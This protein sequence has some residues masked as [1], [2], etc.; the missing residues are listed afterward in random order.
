M[1]PATDLL[2]RQAN[3]EANGSDTPALVLLHFFGGSRREW[4]EAGVSLASDFRVLS[5]DTP[6]F[7]EANNVP[8]YSVSEMA[9]SFAATLAEMQLK[10]FVLVGHSMTGKVAAVMASREL[11]GLE[12][13]V[14]LT[15]SPVSPE[16]IAPGDR[17]GMLA[18]AVP[19]RADAEQ[20]VRE[21]SC[22]PMHAEVFN[23]AVEDRLRANPDAWRAWLEKGSYE[24]WSEQV[25]T[26]DLPTLVIAAEKDK[27][28]GP[29]VQREFTMP[30]FTNARLEVIA[31][32]G[33]L[34]PME[35]PNRLARLLRDFAGTEGVSQRREN[36]SLSQNR[37]VAARG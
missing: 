1:L 9:D 22:L 7:G 24:D 30:H 18:Q 17:A 25:G 27:S 32:S 8:G 10:R 5:I 13:L 6:G 37:D 2:I 4:A 15:A 36:R 26:L 23:R 31:G 14:L 20:Y 33:H 29:V 12:K 35:A 28:L 16:P 3:H 11:P 34:V 19:T 21:N